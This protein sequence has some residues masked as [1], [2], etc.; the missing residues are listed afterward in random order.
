MKI[1]LTKKQYK[2]GVERWAEAIYMSQYLPF[3]SPQMPIWKFVSPKL[4]KDLRRIAKAAFD[5]F[6]RRCEEDG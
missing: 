6:I 2:E 1:K 4:K 3:Y 5:E